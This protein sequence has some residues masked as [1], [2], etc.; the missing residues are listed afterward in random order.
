MGTGFV[1]C[2]GF[3]DV[4]TAVR[5]ARTPSRGIRTGGF[6]LMM[7]QKRRYTNSLTSLIFPGSLFPA[8]TRF[9]GQTGWM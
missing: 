4:P 1:W 6:S 5:S 3:Q 9:T 8:V 2:Y 7:R